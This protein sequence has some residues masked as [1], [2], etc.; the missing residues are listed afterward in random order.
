MRVLE[1]TECRYEPE[2]CGVH[3]GERRRAERDGTDERLAA[4]QP[5][6]RDGE[7]A[8]EAGFGRSALIARLC[9]PREHEERGG[10]GRE[11]AGACA[12]MQTRFEQLVGPRLENERMSG[13]ECEVDEP[14]ELQSCRAQPERSPCEQ[15]AFRSPRVRQAGSGHDVGD[16]DGARGEGESG[17]QRA[18]LAVALAQEQRERRQRIDAGRAE[19]G[20]PLGPAVEQQRGGEHEEAAAAERERRRKR[21]EVAHATH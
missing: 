19:E 15:R 3:G 17:E 12:R 10:D 13:R 8:Q 14:G 18:E 21:T 20:D 7:R 1:R 5:R 4:G 9:R 2:R 6:E 16:A 11:R